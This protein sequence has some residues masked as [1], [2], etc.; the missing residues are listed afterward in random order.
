[1]TA[2]PI[3]VTVTRHKCPFCSRTH[4]RPVRACEHM[5]RCWFNPE[6]HGCKT[7]KHFEQDPG[8]PDVGLMGGE[9]C[10]LGVSLAGRPTC[11]TCNGRG[12]TF[13]L[14]TLG[15]SECRECGG[16]GAEIKPG[17]IVHCEHWEAAL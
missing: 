13:D 10:G 8:E 11:V 7:C 12:E 17:P 15:A 16:D 9:G 1:M 5:A 2:Q 3:A 6:A 14:G 4:S